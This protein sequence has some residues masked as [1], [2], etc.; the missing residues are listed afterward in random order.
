M[1]L[2]LS[3]PAP[4][5]SPLCRTISQPAPLKARHFTKHLAH[6]R[7]P[8]DALAWAELEHL[9]LTQTEPAN[10]DHLLS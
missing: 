5:A 8:G 1:S 9:L 4:E 6:G 3:S 2:E 7:M 10:K